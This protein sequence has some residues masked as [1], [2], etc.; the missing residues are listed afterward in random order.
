MDDRWY[1]RIAIATA[2]SLL[3]WVPA[4]VWLSGG[5]DAPRTASAALAVTSAILLCVF[6]VASAL[7]IYYGRRRI[8]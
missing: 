7:H 1:T 4:L 8:S 5:E 2:V 3:T 6:I